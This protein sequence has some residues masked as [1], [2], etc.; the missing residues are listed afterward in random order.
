MLRDIQ[1]GKS[2]IWSLGGLAA[3]TL[4]VA[5]IFVMVPRKGTTDVD[6]STVG[7]SE[8]TEQT[9]VPIGHGGTPDAPKAAD[10]VDSTPPPPRQEQAK[11]SESETVDQVQPA[12]LVERVPSESWQVENVSIEPSAFLFA[13]GKPP[14]IQWSMPAPADRRYIVAS[15]SLTWDGR[16]S[17]TLTSKISPAGLPTLRLTDGTNRYLPLGRLT[18]RRNHLQP[19][20]QESMEFAAGETKMLDVAF[21]VPS[22]VGQITLIVD[23]KRCGEFDWE[24]PSMVTPQDLVG[25]WRRAQPQFHALR[26]EDTLANGIAD[27]ACRT[28]RI[29]ETTGGIVELQIPCANGRSMPLLES[30]AKD[31]LNIRIKSGTDERPCRLRV[32]DRAKAL[33]LYVGESESAAFLYERLEG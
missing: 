13:V 5:A 12:A 7:R 8:K 32:I 30:V 14:K 16:D 26:Y 28:L 15:L 29:T 20:S 18:D 21:L 10:P 11:T 24:A 23:G 22:H 27:P 1:F 4:A 31:V 6:S 25:N 17:H 19:L 3:V 9:I 33:L 2:F